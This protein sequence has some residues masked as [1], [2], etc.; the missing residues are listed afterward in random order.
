MIAGLLSRSRHERRHAFD[1]LP[2]DRDAA[3]AAREI[4]VFDEDASVRARA[5]MFLGKCAP[6][7]ATPALYDALHDAM[8][9][10]R[11]A[12][13]RALARTGGS[14]ERLEE[15]ALHDPIWWVRRAAI[16]S[17]AMLGGSIAMLREALE[18]PFW[19]VRS[20][21]VRALLS[22]GEDDLA[23]KL[24]PATSARSEGALAYIARRLGEK[25][26]IATGALDMPNAGVARLDPDPA[27]A[28]A[29]LERGDP[30]TTAFLV[31]CLGDPH[32]SLRTVARKRLARTPDL[33]ALE[34]ALLWLEEPRIPHAA[35]TVIALLD[36]LDR[37]DVDPLLDIA[38]TRGEVGA[39]AWATS[40]VGLTGDASRVDALLAHSRSEHAIVRCAVVAALGALGEVGAIVSALGDSDVR[41]VRT[42]V[43]ALADIDPTNAALASLE[44]NDPIARRALV[45][46]ADARGDVDTLLAFSDDPDPR[47]RA[48]ATRARA[49]RG[50]RDP[51]WSSD[52]DP[53]I[54][55]AALDPASAKRL[56]ASDPHPW[57]RRAAFG[58][59]P[60]AELASRSDDPW[61]K[62]RAVARLDPRKDLVTLLRLARDQSPAV[63]AA[64]ADALER[65]EI[66]SALDALL[67]S[68]RLGEQE[69]IAALAHRSRH[70]EESDLERLRSA[71]ENASPAVRAWLA[72]ILSPSESTP[73]VRTI[74]DAPVR[75]LGK[76]GMSVPAV[77]VSGAGILPSGAYADALY[78]GARF[79]FWEPR[80]HTLGR[81]LARERRAAIACG[82]YEASERAI[83]ADVDRYLRRLRRDVLD[84]FLLFWVRSPSRVEADAFEVLARLKKQGKIRAFGFSTH[85]RELA[86]NA[87]RARDWDVLMTRH[88]AVHPG[89]EAK[90]FPLARE[91]S[92]GVL[93]FSALSYGR[94]LA[95]DV[96]TAPEAYGYSLA[97]PGVSA[98]L[99][100]P[101]TAQEL[102]ENLTVLS[103]PA[104]SSD[105]QAALR[106][107]GKRV[108]E[109]SRDFARS[110]RRHPLRLADATADLGDWLDREEV[111]DP[112]FE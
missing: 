5:A 98:C 35:Q 21:A 83:T 18:D 61:L 63:R 81:M 82:T 25:A 71:Q 86:E 97:Q 37:E 73:R 90:V 105:R 52:P 42:A 102:R 106:E 54:R 41:V 1:R 15:I 93:G 22:R 50:E 58:L 4:L 66:D 53:W 19:R 47:T 65:K 91:K 28:T 51:A 7:I 44:T 16:V 17:S 40:Y 62:T 55:M 32:R 96:V 34:L 14:V 11:H 103:A 59:H 108:H 29:R 23:T 33:R 94:V 60:D 92:V 20:A 77:I 57:V 74:A 109:E 78:A 88:S 107:H 89:A 68:D 8:P 99:T 45:I 76:T 38:F 95:P 9:L 67:A 80:Y 24:G 72:D 49:E 64:A 112:R 36:A 12:A 2:I 10:V 70:F 27:V 79:F 100:A 84:V 110:I 43:L 85:D 3:Y 111:R 48:L 101:R 13:V 31:E 87:L 30:S 56:L 75:P 69:R 46:A 6:D 39:L 26:P 104:L